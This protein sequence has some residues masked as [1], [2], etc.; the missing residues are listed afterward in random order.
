[1]SHTIAHHC[2]FSAGSPP[3]CKQQGSGGAHKSSCMDLAQSG[4][5]FG[6]FC[7]LPLAG[8]QPIVS[9]GVGSKNGPMCGSVG[10]GGGEAAGGL[11]MACGRIT[12]LCSVAKSS[13]QNGLPRMPPPP[14]FEQQHPHYRAFHVKRPRN[15][16]RCLGPLHRSLADS[17][18]IISPSLS[19][20]PTPLLLQCPI[21]Y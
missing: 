16:G 11:C 3:L 19:P 20:T 13:A 8:N 1:M 4:H 12:S 2:D 21:C 18:A 10:G 9:G 17:A 5:P 6:H 15:I 7:S 14:P